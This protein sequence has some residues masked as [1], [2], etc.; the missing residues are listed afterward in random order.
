GRP[1][2][3]AKQYGNLGGVCRA[4]GDTAG[5]REWWTRALELFRRIGMTREGGLVQKWLDDLDRG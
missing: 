4:R 1:E 2:G 3:M 5:A